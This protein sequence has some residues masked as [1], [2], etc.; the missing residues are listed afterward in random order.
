MDEINKSLMLYIEKEI[1]PIYKNND[2]GHEIDHINY[3][4]NRCLRFKEQFDDININMLYTIAAFHDLAYRIDKDNHEILSAKIF[5]ENNDMKHFFSDEER[6]IIKDAIED[7]RAS[8][9]EEPRNVYGKIISS[10]DRNTD[11][12]SAL[13][14]TYSYTVKYYP[15]FSL[16]QLIDEGYN[17]IKDKFGETGYAKVYLKDDEYDQFK[18]EVNELLY[19]KNLFAK[20][21]IEVNGILPI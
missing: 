17:H 7:H 13:K 18:K 5:F 3:V 9:K 4:I 11:I 14:R 20:R 12:V 15:D 21:Y 16:E 19:D 1:F 6:I 2:S 8:K 10:A